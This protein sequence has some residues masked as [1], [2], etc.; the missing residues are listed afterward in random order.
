MTVGDAGM[1]IN[2]NA[3]WLAPGICRIW[4]LVWGDFWKVDG[5]F[6]YRMYWNVDGAAGLAEKR[7]ERLV[8]CVAGV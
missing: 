6:G 8:K 5:V 7:A 3:A 2:V 1:T 4:N